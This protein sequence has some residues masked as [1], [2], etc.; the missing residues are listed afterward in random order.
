MIKK[1][2]KVDSNDLNDL[3][4]N[5]N[6][7]EK[8]LKYL[9]YTYYGYDKII[10]NNAYFSLLNFYIL[11]TKFIVKD[12][13]N[14]NL[15]VEE[16][17]NILVY[18]GQENINLT[19][20]ADRNL[21][22]NIIH[23]IPFTF[24]FINNNNEIE[25][26]NSN[27]FYYEITILEQN[28]VSWSTETIAIGYGN[29]EINVNSIP[30][31]KNDTFGYHLDDGSFQKNGNYYKNYG[32]IGKQGDIFGAGI[33]FIN[34]NLY[35]SF[36]TINGYLIQDDIEPFEIK[37]D[38]TPIIGYSHSHKIKYNF[39]KDKF[40]FNLSEFISSNKIISNYNVLFNDKIDFYDNSDKIKQ[41]FNF[42]NNTHFFTFVNTNQNLF[43][44][45]NE[46]ITTLGGIL[47]NM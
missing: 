44:N 30:G 17:N 9:I 11:P 18:K 21:P 37:Y 35:K 15:I 1:I 19:I 3:S 39:G 26:F 32:P 42:L 4:K 7:T 33:I 34:N 47:F 10:I 31:W 22:N 20:F 38:I 13:K 6:L 45:E 2:L 16:N 23:P 25:L 36:F 14:E 27:I 41:K 8:Y 24:P 43:T 5:K 29:I 46:L 40:N 28:R 12:Y